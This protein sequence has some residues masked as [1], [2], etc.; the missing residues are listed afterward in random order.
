MAKG[1]QGSKLPMDKS[2]M[3]KMEQDEDMMDK[4]SGG[5]GSKKGGKG[6]GCK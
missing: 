3:G 6:G 1:K 2:K 5:K 4:K